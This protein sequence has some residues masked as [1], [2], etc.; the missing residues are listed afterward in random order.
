MGW[1][2]R[3]DCIAKNVEFRSNDIEGA[4][5]ELES[6]DQDHSYS[7]Y[8]TLNIKAVDE[9]GKPLQDAEVTIFDKSNTVVTQTKTDEKG[10]LQTELEEYSVDGKEKKFISPYTVSIGNY[11][12]IV[13]LNK[14][15]EI[16]CTVSR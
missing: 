3:E 15:T 8:W 5:F 7:V 12:K 14:N 9:K 16:T 4:K 1:K 10:K 2:E 6:T 11:K 13:E